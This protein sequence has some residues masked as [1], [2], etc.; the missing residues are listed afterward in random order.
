[1]VSKLVGP[2][3]MSA[4]ALARQMGVAQ[5]TLSRWLRE[6]GTNG[7]TVQRNRRT[8]MAKNQHARRRPDDL[9]FEEKVRIV[10]AA[11]NLS[12]EELGAFLRKEGL[13]G[14]D[15]QRWK[16]AM[17]EALANTTGRAKSRRSKEAKKFKKLERELNR[18]DKALAE[19]AAL[20]VL[21]KKAEEIWGDEGDDT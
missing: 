19:T 20:L 9:S 1:M 3:G 8:P 15:L 7:G 6:A 17:R 10:A 13:H 12:D 18:K 14:A 21:K 5:G 16:E 11:Q 4:T 2:N